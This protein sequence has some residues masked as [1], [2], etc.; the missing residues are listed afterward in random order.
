MSGVFL[1]N[2]RLVGRRSRL[3]RLNR[4][5]ILKELGHRGQLREVV[6][7]H[8]VFK[9]H[10]IQQIVL[11]NLRGWGILKGLIDVAASLQS[12]LTSSRSSPIL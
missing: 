11:V 2:R 12:S 5:S 1:V 9:P 10:F 3:A 7:G 4:P 6:L 8:G